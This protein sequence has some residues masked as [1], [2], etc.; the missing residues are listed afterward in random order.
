MQYLPSLSTINIPIFSPSMLPDSLLSLLF[1][2]GPTIAFIPQ[3]CR[4]KILFSPL[5]SLA[6]IVS[7][8]TKIFHYSV[9]RYSIILLY[10]FVLLVA[11]HFYL[12]KNYHFPLRR[13]EMKVFVPNL[14]MRHGLAAYA[15]GV[16]AL[17]IATLCLMDALGLGLLFGGIACIMDLLITVLQLIIYSSAK[18]KPSELF[19]FWV[20][21]DLIKLWMMIMYYKTPI[22]Y[23]ACI[24]GQIAMN[25]YVLMR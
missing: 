3:I 5:L 22:E 4:K 2:A 10:Q 11:L 20:L 13:I 17:A 14:C 9:T 1:I 24:V 6:T 8:I 12:I 15:S 19:V 21:G 16:I 7:N 18:D 25:A 23:N